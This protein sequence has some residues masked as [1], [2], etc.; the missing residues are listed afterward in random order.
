MSVSAMMDGVKQREGEQEM[1]KFTADDLVAEVTETLTHKT[2]RT[3]N[4]EQEIKV[5]LIGQVG[6]QK[7]A[8]FEDRSRLV[9]GVVL[10]DR[11]DGHSVMRQYD[12][13]QYTHLPFDEKER[14][15]IKPFS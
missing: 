15:N 3:Y 2:G 4:G 6:E 10:V 13:T 9:D 8:Y 1:V 12:L 7:L 11:F 5:S 14:L